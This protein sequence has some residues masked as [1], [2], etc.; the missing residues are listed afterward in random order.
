MK[1]DLSNKTALVC[2]ASQGIGAAIAE[3]FAEAGARV[4][5]LARNVHKLKDVSENLS[6]K[7]LKH[8]YLKVDFDAPE[9]SI[10]FLRDQLGDTPKIDILVNNSGGPKPGPAY[11]ESTEN[12]RLGLNRH[13][14]MSQYLTQMVLPYMSKKKWGRIINVIS[15]GARE[16]VHNLGVSNTVRGAMVS[17]AKTLSKELGNHGITV[18]NILPGHTATERLEKLIATNA[19][20]N[21]RS[22][23]E[24]KNQLISKIPAERLAEPSEPAYLA[25]FLASHQASFINGV[26]IPVDGGYLNSI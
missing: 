18:N 20:N 2:G 6:N 17:W 11:S 24:E 13:L 21:N 7:D 23:E 5:L 8:S 10:T 12:F 26:S 15:I 9:D 14:I 4:V 19:K 16:P 25:C 3:Q 22:V 1:I